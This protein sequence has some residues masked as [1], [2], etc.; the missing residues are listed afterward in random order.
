MAQISASRQLRMRPEFGLGVVGLD[1]ELSRGEHH[2]RGERSLTALRSQHFVDLEKRE[3]AVPQVDL[4]L[5]DLFCSSSL[6]VCGHVGAS[7]PRAFGLNIWHPRKLGR[8]GLDER[9]F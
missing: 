3:P 2:K 1:Q 8:I 9:I 4:R 7:F 6:M 5:Q